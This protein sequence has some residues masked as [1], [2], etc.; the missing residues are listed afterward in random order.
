MEGDSQQYIASHSAARFGATVEIPYALA[1]GVTV[2]EANTRAFGADLGRAVACYIRG[3]GC[4]D[5]KD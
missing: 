5:R 3:E 1:G 2:S 4:G